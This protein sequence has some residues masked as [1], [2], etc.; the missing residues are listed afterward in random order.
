MASFIW[1]HLEM[2]LSPTSSPRVNVSL[3]ASSCSVP[4]GR[5]L[6][7]LIQGDL[8]GVGARSGR[9]PMVAHVAISG[10]HHGV[11]GWSEGCCV[12]LLGIVGKCFYAF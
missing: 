12:V 10:G 5:T 7:W 1:R 6:I 3:V 11:F 4:S 9:I 2:W 8:D